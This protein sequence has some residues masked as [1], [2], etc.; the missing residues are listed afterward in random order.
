MCFV[1]EQVCMKLLSD[2]HKKQEI[3]TPTRRTMKKDMFKW[4][5]LN[6]IIDCDI[7]SRRLTK[8]FSLLFTETKTSCIMI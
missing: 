8:A 3:N 5:G 6:S 7:N 4:F 2:E 1:Y